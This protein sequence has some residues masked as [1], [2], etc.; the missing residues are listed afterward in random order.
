[1][2]PCGR[3][4]LT[5][6]LA[7]AAMCCH[8]FGHCMTSWLC[9]SVQNLCLH[10]RYTHTTSTSLVEMG[11][12]QMYH[13]F[14]FSSHYYTA[15]DIWFKTTLLEMYT[16]VHSQQLLEWHLQWCCTAESRSGGCRENTLS[17]H[18]HWLGEITRYY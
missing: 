18:T 5:P 13:L 3:K 15:K 7:M 1:M 17:V 16:P 8:P 9:I 10:N 6:V 14:S 12:N 2:Q 11:S 4:V